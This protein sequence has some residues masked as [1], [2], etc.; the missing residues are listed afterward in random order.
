MLAMHDIVSYCL[1]FSIMHVTGFF[2]VCS[3]VRQ[4]KKLVFYPLFS[5]TSQ[6]WGDA[7]R[8]DILSPC[9]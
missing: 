1:P 4:V 5:M 7:P 3:Q 8:V 2:S 9:V 6:V